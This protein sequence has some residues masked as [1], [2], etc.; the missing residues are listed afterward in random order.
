MPGYDH[1][2]DTVSKLSARG[3]AD[4]WLWTGGLV[5]YAALMGCFAAGLH[6]RLGSGSR[7][8]VLWSAVAT[9]AA[10][11]AGVAV[12]RDD[13][14]P[15]GFFTVEGAV[16][17]V[18]SGIAFGALVL[19]MLA[20]VVAAPVDQA[21]RSLRAITLVVGTAMTGVGIAFLFTPPAVQGVP[22]RI[23]VGLA[24]VWIVA[25]AARSM[26]APGST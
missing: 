22:Q 21:L 26:S 5:A 12:F 19:A 3:I 17:D 9:H 18:L 16:H 4:R 7:S 20:V 23:F 11:M 14:R 6:R 24:A 15:G 25:F 8:R 1:V 2:A 13:L 10:L